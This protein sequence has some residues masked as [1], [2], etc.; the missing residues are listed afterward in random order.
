MTT[1]NELRVMSALMDGDKYGLE[2]VAA[3]KESGTV[4]LLGSLYNVLRRLE[5]NGFVS[6]YWGE[7]TSE[8]GGN[9]RRYYKINA[10]GVDALRKEQM[11]FAHQWGIKIIKTS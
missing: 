2:I 11:A 4:L 3:V 6:S 10:K 8:R 9:K 5:K 1:L 7:E